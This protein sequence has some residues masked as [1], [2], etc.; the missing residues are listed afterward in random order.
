MA[1]GLQQLQQPGCLLLFI[2]FAVQL[3]RN[4]NCTLITSPNPVVGPV[5]CVHEHQLCLHLLGKY[6]GKVGAE[7]NMWA[8]CC[9]PVHLSKHTLML[10]PAEWHMLCCSALI[11]KT[12]E[13]EWGS[14]KGCLLVT[15]SLPPGTP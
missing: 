10:W 2:Q 15:C 13:C 11:A 1:M 12:Q 14:E 3:P 7:N 9:T 6:A 8:D 5:A 4:A